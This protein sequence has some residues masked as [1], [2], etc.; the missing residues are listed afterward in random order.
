[1]QLKRYSLYLIFLCAL[2]PAFS[3]SQ[4]VKIKGKAHASHIGKP[5]SVLAFGDLITYTKT[6]EAIDTVDKDG[7]FE[8]DLQIDHTQPI[9]LQ[10]ENLFG[11]LYIQPNYVYGV[12]FPEK[13]KELD[14]RGDVEEQV[15]IGVISADTTEL[16]TLIIDYNKIYNKMFE[17]A[18]S[19][20]LNKNRIYNKLDT[21]QLIAGWRYK[22]IK[23]NYFKSYVHYSIAELNANASRGKNFLASSFISGKPVQH[24]HFEYMT[25]FNAFFKGYVEAYSS[26][27]KTENIHHLINTVTQYTA[28]NAYL[29]NDPLLVNDT[30][31]ELV[32]IKSL[33]DYYYNPQFSREMVLAVIEQ[34]ANATKIKEHKKILNNILLVA[35]NLSVGMK[36]PDFVAYDRTGKMVTLGDFKGRYVYLNFFSTKSVSSLK[37]MPKIAELVKKY[38]DKMAFVSICTDDSIKNYKNYLKANPKFTWPIW[39][40]YAANDGK[41]AYDVYNLKAVPAFFFI[42]QFG[43]LA[44]S[45]ANAPTQGFEYKLKALFKPKKKDTKIGIR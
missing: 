34:T 21:L 7:Y 4:N 20:F 25:F 35:Y 16:N 14:I 9:E 36:A 1:M 26:T 38:G 15:L 5:I 27:K 28:V 23:N 32:I 12:T 24:N 40:N 8:L 43:N 33:W 10:I 45:P 37:E 39:F 44:Q 19:E 42:N 11:K 3:F 17:N 22:N 30:L 29:K 41:T 31:R 2:A 13:D 6:R 18:G